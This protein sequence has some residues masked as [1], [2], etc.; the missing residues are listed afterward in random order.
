MDEAGGELEGVE[1]QTDAA[2]DGEVPDGGD[3]AALEAEQED[4]GDAEGGLQGGDGRRRPP[5][6]RGRA[7]AR[8]HEDAAP[9]GQDGDLDERQVDR[10][11]EPE[12][13]DVLVGSRRSAGER[14]GDGGVESAK[15]GRPYVVRLDCVPE[16]QVPVVHEEARSAD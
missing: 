10:V 3:G 12:D 15:R 4:G 6:A 14:G 16:Q 7:R 9:L 2:G 5:E 13:E 11:E 8:Q 1:G